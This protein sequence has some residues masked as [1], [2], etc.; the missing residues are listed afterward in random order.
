MVSVTQLAQ[1]LLKLN[2]QT[3]SARLSF[4]HWVKNFLD[5]NAELQADMI[6]RF[7]DHALLIS[8]WQT[9]SQLLGETVAQDLLLFSRSH[10]LN[11]DPKDIRHA[12]QLQTIELSHSSD[13]LSAIEAHMETSKAHGKFKILPLNNHQILTIQATPNQGFLV[14]VFTNQMKVAGHQLKPLAPL[15]QLQYSSQLELIPGLVQIL[16]TGHTAWSK[17]Q[18]DD[19]GCH[20]LLVKGYIFQKAEVFIGKNMSL[21]PEL[22]YGLKQLER[23]YIDLRSDPLY[24]ELASMLEK[25]LNLIGTQHPEAYRLADTALRKGRLALKNIFPDD[26]LLRLLVTNLEYRITEG[27]QVFENGPQPETDESCL[28]PQ[29]I[30]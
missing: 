30:N 12:H 13:L 3:H 6:D 23:F 18:I 9:N 14:R 7:Y 25:A 2:P 24:Q 11:F 19:D 29:P 8:H 15:T 17:F 20:G 21:Y 4:Y 10:T 1:F 26:K 16:Q 28:L 22:Y 5:L 27:H